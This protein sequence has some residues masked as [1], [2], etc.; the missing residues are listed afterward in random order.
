MSWIRDAGRVASAATLAMFWVTLSTAAAACSTGEGGTAGDASAE[1]ARTEEPAV[2]ESAGQEA[3]QERSPQEAPQEGQ[4]EEEAAPIR[5]PSKEVQETIDRFKQLDP[6]LSEF[7]DNAA[8]YVVFASIGK[9]GLG[10]GGAHGNGEVIARGKGAIGKSSITQI[11]VGLQIGGQEYS[12][13]IFFETDLDLERFTKGGLEL[14]AQVSA[15]AITAGAADGA[16]YKDGV[17]VF[18]RTKSGMMGEASVGGQQF[19]Y[20]PY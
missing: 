11:T 19:S 15:V 1:A 9:G 6:T 17:A 4:G 16:N 3:D 14:A 13:I 18:T 10:I 8:G 2:G 7:F 5:Q 12:E 20:E